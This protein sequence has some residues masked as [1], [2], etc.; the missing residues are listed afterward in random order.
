MGRIVVSQNNMVISLMVNPVA[1][2]CQDLAEVLG[3]KKLAICS[4]GNLDDFF[5]NGGWNGF[6]VLV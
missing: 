3:L 6:V 4:Q 2:F 1:N 5:V